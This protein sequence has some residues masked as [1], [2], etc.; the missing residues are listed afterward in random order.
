MIET[1]YLIL[2]Q[3]IFLFISDDKFRRG[4]VKG[5]FVSHPAPFFLIMPNLTFCVPPF[6]GLVLLQYDFRIWCELSPGHS[7]SKSV[8]HF[9]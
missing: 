8:F 2:F 3:G 5:G 6:Y 1:P 9:R 7:S 4:P